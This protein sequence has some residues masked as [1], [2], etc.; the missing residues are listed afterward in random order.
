[1]FKVAE[2]LKTLVRFMA[3][4]QQAVLTHSRVC[5]RFVEFCAKFDIHALFR[6]L[7]YHECDI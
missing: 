2:P 5:S 6:T 3:S 1:M 4:S 7:E